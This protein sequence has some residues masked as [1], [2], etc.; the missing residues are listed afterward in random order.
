MAHGSSVSAETYWGRNLKDAPAYGIPEAARYLAIPPSTL[1]S[2]AIGQNYRYQGE[3]RRFEPVFQI[4]D[5]ERRLL[6]FT[7]VCEAHVCEALRNSHGFPL[8]HIRRAINVLT[9][10]FPG[11][12]HPLVDHGLSVFGKD[13][14]VKRLE[15][16]EVINL[17]THG[18]TAFKELLDLY[19]ERVEYDQDELSR[20]FPFTWTG[21]SRNAPRIVVLDPSVLS[22][23]PVI[24]DTRIAT[25]VVFERWAAGESI[26]ALADDYGRRLDEIQEALRCE[27]SRAA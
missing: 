18:Q 3:V 22:G 23:R 26:V 2:W 13:L 15:D 4:A 17:T 6:S 27:T 1:A 20:L 12:K 14:W 10:L 21:V 24:K 19:L 9:G 25:S 5:L 11:S 8:Q 7:N 16:D